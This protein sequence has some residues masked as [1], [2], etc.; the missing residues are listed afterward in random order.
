MTHD[1]LREA[2]SGKYVVLKLPPPNGQGETR[3]LCGRRGPRGYV[4]SGTP[5]R[6]QLVRFLSSAVLR[7]LDKKA[8]KEE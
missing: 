7:H 5:E 3:R 8:G 2:C 1:K 6:G 4:L